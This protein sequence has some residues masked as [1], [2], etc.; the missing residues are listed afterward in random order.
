VSLSDGRIASERRN[1]HKLPASELS[2]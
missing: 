2:W 1:P